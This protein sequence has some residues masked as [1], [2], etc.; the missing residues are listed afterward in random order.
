LNPA[1]VSTTTSY[2]ATVPDGTTSMAVTATT[3]DAG[4][5]ATY[6]SSAGACA[7][8]TCPIAA[9]GA[10][11]ITITVTA[12]DGA[13]QTYVLVVTVAPPGASS[14]ASLS[15][16]A[17]S[18]G[19]LNP[20]FVSTTTSYAAAVP[21]GTASVTV[22]AMANDSAATVT[23]TPCDA[24]DA[25]RFTSPGIPG[26]ST[27]RGWATLAS[28]AVCPLSVG[29]NTITI[30]IT[31]S[32]GSVQEYT[33][34]IVRAAPLTT[35]GLVWP[36]IGVPEGGMPVSLFGTG[37][38]VATGVRVS[39]SLTNTLVPFT[40]TGDVRIDFVMPSGEAGTAA[41]IVVETSDGGS[42]TALQAFRYVGP[43]VLVVDGDAAVV[44]TVNGITITMPPQGVSGSFYLTMTPQPP[45]SGLPGNVLMHSFRLDA[46]LN[47][48]P[49]ASLTNPVTIQL[50]I[51]ENIF[52][53]GDGERPWLY[54][55]VGGEER[56]ERGEEREEERSALTSHS[57]PLTS[58]SAGRWI[59]VRGQQ[60]EPT[61]R[62]MTVALRPMG[63]YALSTAYLRANWFPLV[64]VLR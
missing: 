64:P 27:M 33:I 3:N 45:Q 54:Q 42:T 40:T 19:S 49:L 25:A 52:A 46:L 37:F 10:T 59:L 4:A 6:A 38:S 48:T 5:S 43:V 35:I 2:A 34:T 1:F 41:D 12:S 15:E 32:D 18:V 7:G 30:T 14:D 58:L 21:N 61:T 39:N 23:F 56:G 47:G 28:S 62:I 20:A 11:T 13:L 50:P 57:S 53:I 51:D 24:V 16:L 17:L 31:A 8:A 22:T 55:W 26:M 44:T 36:L 60:Y 63:E 29:M 9:S